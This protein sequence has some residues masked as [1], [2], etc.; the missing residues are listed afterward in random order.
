MFSWIW[1]KAISQWTSI[2]NYIDK[3]NTKVIVKKIETN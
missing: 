1:K 2:K 3:L